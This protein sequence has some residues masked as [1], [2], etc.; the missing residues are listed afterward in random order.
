MKFEEIKQ[1][2]ELLKVIKDHEWKVFIKRYPYMIRL[3][4]E[5]EYS[6]VK[7]NIYWN[8]KGKFTKISTHL[9]HPKKGKGQMFRKL[10]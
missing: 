10:F 8:G 5:F 6:E 4:K 3:R 1:K 2:D 9:N 7:M